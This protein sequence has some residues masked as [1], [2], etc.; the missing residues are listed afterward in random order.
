MQE[1]CTLCGTVRVK[2]VT[3]LDDSYC[4]ACGNESKFKDVLDE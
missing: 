2:N 4:Q 3:R 1:Y